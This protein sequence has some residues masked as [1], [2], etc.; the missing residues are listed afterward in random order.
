[1]NR[2]HLIIPAL[3]FAV[4]SGQVAAESVCR[5]LDYDTAFSAPASATLATPAFSSLRQPVSNTDIAAGFTTQRLSAPVSPQTSRGGAYGFFDA[6]TYIKASYGTLTGRALYKNGTARDLQG[7][8]TTDADILFPFFTT[9]EVG[10]DLEREV[11]SFG[12][13]YAGSFG[14]PTIF[15]V[16]GGYTAV[17]DCRRRDPRPKNTVG[18]LDAAFSAGVFLGTHAFAATVSAGKYKQTNSIMFVSELGENR[19]Y[20]T[21]GLG[22]HYARFSGQGRNSHYSGSRF[23]AALAA[24]PRHGVGAFGSA[25]FS[26]FSFTKQLVD[27]NRLPLQ[28]AAHTQWEVQAGWTAASW[29]VSATW[30]HDRRTGTENI[31]GDPAGGVFPLLFG[32]DTYRFRSHSATVQ[33]VWRHRTALATLDIDAAASYG[34]RHSTLFANSPRNLRT[35]A[36]QVGL[37]ARFCRFAS[38]KWLLHTA[39]HLYATLP[40]DCS[41]DGMPEAV[42]FPATVTSDALEAARLRR[43]DSRLELGID[44]MLPAGRSIGLR[45]AGGIYAVEAHRRGFMGGAEAVFSF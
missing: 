44:R 40:S 19:I 31:F 23:G 32:I 7:S 11:Y 14:G 25:S 6:S 24:F 15:G 37:G 16:E 30:R 21:S 27:L 18:R 39:A 1:M 5:P 33:G 28:H 13:S 10:G 26:R 22:T 12:G 20:H 34:R 29:R 9:D 42:A 35:S 3:I 41:L 8:E 36:A 4:V 17:Q 45:V 43:L 38:P 2:K